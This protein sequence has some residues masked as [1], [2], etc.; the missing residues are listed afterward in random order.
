MTEIQKIIK[1]IE[2]SGFLT[3][4]KVGQKLSSKNWKVS[5]GETYLDYDEKKSRE[6]DIQAYKVKNN[7]DVNF[8][9]VFTV[10]IEV[11]YEPKNPWVVF[12]RGDRGQIFKLDKWCF[13]G[14]E[15]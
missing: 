9:L 10:F 15:E 1:D 11:K 4:L 5:F 13:P 12:M 7:K 14:N 6:I 3:E 8:Q 2:K